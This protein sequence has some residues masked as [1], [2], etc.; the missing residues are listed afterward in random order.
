MVGMAYHARPRA[1]D[2]EAMRK[3]LTKTIELFTW[4]TCWVKRN[5]RLNLREL[6]NPVK[7]NLGSGLLNAPGWICVDGSLN[8]LFATW[9]KPVHAILYRMSGSS[10]LM[11][12]DEY[13]SILSE[14]RFIHHNLEWNLPLVN[15][16]VDFFFSSLCLEHLYRPVGER[17]VS[18]CLRALR[19]GG[20]LRVAV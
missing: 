14:N 19:R 9:P 2:D 7:V 5:Q 20:V 15:D 4:L 18:E 6:G 10:T 12:F 17:F 8:A 13:H 1:L 11:S 3:Y 16:S